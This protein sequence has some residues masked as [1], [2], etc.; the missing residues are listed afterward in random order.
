MRGNVIAGNT[1]NLYASGGQHFN[2]KKVQKEIGEK[3]VA[4]RQDVSYNSQASGEE[5]ASGE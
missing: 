1:Y 3:T 4:I 2:R 5:P